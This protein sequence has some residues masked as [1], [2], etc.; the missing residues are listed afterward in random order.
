MKSIGHLN[1]KCDAKKKVKKHTEGNNK[2]LNTI[3]AC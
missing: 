2:T 3:A 1:V